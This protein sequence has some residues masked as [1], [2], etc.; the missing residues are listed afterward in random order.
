MKAFVL[1]TLLA[2]PT[3]G[4][5]NALASEHPPN[6]LWIM[7]DDMGYGEP[8]VFGQTN[9]RTPN[10]DRLAA[11]GMRFTDAYAGAPVCAPSRCALMTGLHTGHGWIRGNN[12]N[13]D[14]TDMSLRAN[15]TTVATLL[16]Q[17]G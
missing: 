2:G 9:F 17:A 7:S 11:S 5:H 8:G 14:G 3:A 15:D 10:I 1:A 6:I 16:R 13:P 12:A 4:V